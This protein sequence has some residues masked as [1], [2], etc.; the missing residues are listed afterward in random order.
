MGLMSSG[1]Q[2]KKQKKVKPE[3]S[4]TDFEGDAWTYTCV[5]RESYFFA[6][7]A[8]GKWTQETCHVMLKQF[9]QRIT[10]PTFTDRL[11]IRS[12][13][14][15]DYTYMFPEFFRTDTINYGQPIRIRESGRV[16]DKIRRVIYGNPPPDDI[17]T[18][19]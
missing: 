11:E 18:T 13:G 9:A 1:Q 15:D 10:L 12:D 8:V 17:E 4:T 5:K 16:V 3:S 2:L 14:N 19:E 7:F 6:A